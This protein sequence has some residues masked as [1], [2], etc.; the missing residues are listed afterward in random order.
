MFDEIY[1]SL[2]EHFLDGEIRLTDFSG[3]HHGHG[4][5]V[6]KGSHIRVLYKK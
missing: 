5:H 6:H 3:E 1:K 4:A 2:Q